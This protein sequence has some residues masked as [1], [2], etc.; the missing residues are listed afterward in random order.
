M[1]TMG[2]KTMGPHV[3]VCNFVLL[4]HVIKLYS[5]SSPVRR[6]G[7]CCRSMHRTTIVIWA[8]LINLVYSWATISRQSSTSTNCWN[9]ATR[10][11]LLTVEEWSSYCVY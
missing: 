7:Y 9:I 6:V 1:Y 10:V 11:R 4:F 2:Q 5:S 8:W 3:G